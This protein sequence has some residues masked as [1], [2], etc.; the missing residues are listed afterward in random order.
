MNLEIVSIAVIVMIA[1]GLVLSSILAAAYRGLYVYEDPRIEQVES[2]LPGTN[3][4]ACGSPGC[5][6]FAEQVVSGAAA[7]G[8]CTVSSAEGREAIADY[9]GVDGGGDERQVARL[10]CAGGSHVARQRARYEGIGTCRA[11]NLVAGGG[12]GCAWGCLGYG[13]CRDVCTFDAIVMDR[14]ALP[15]VDD[16]LCTACGD[17]V[18]ICPKALFSLQ[19]VSRRL[20]VACK[21]LAFGDEAEA[22]CEVACNACGRCVADAPPGLMRMADNLAVANYELNHLANSSIIQ[23]CPTGAIVW[24]K[25]Q[26]GV[27]KGTSAK[28][29]VRHTPLPLG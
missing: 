23:R 11:A 29:I 21:N 28:L 20:W 6:A 15:V 9:L 12:K 18:D 24:L 13:D 25:Q 22:E 5:A 27:A 14:H 10:A 26:G 7:P 2:M 17:C 8:T 4:G 16:A 1:L 3:C 19:P